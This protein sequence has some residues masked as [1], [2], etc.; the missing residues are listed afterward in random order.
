MIKFT[1]MYHKRS[2]GYEVKATI[3]LKKPNMKPDEFKRRMEDMHLKLE[4]VIPASLKA[5]YNQT[6]DDLIVIIRTEQ[7]THAQSLTHKM[8]DFINSAALAAH[9]S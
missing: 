3:P 8:S 6:T 2:P 5:K 1:V 4:Q 7:S 9:I